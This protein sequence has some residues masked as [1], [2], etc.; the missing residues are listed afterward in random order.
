MNPWH[1]VRLLNAL[2]NG[3]MAVAAA[4]LLYGAVMW[5][6]QRPAFALQTLVIEPSRPDQ[7]LQHVTTA[8]LRSAG[9]TQ[10]KGNFFSL[11]LETVRER[12]E[13][14]PWVRRA[15]VRRVWPD[16]LRVG[17][18]EHQPLAIWSDGRLVNRQ[19]ELFSANV[20]DA[21]AVTDLLE[22]NGPA[23][24]EALVTRRWAELR[25]QLAPLGRTPESVMLSSRYAWS[26]RLDDGLM[27]LLGREQD[28][29]IADR[30][31]RWVTV[32]QQVQSRLSRDIVSVDL[33]YPNGFVVRAPGALDSKP[34]L[35]GKRTP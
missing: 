3:L 25:E 16:T 31:S 8:V 2:A 14:V 34:T 24:S 10:F 15:E 28:T 26:A 5:L 20:A 17:I 9:A 4:A 33:R 18:E 7:A 12:Y 35:E 11:N 27:L 30:I 23:G 6:T 32:H 1:D 13:Q 29:S 21:E 19:G 22:F